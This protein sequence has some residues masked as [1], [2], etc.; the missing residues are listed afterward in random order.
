MVECI[1][2]RRLSTAALLILLS[3]ASF[4]AVPVRIVKT[5]LRPLIRAGAQSQVQFAVLVPQSVSTVDDGKWSMAGGRTTWS[6]AV[7]VPTAVSL[8]FHAAL[9]SLP[10][11]AVLVVRGAKTTTSYRA[12][13]LHRGELWSRI[14]PGDAL[15]FTLTVAAA[16]RDKVLLNIVS[17]QAGYRGL[18][19]GV[20]DNPYYR[21]LKAQAEASDNTACVTNY[22]CQVT[23]SNTPLGSATVALVVG[24][25]FECTGVLINDVPGDNTPYLLTA[26]HC[27]TGK[28]GGGNP[29]AASTLTVYW[30]AVTP[31][32][33]ALGSI[34]D[35]AAATQTGAQT[36]VEQ[37]DAWLIQLDVN[38]LV[39]DAQFAGF[40][41]SGGP[42]QGGYTVHHADGNDKQF[43]GWF[44]QAA[45]VQESDALGSSYLSNF[46]ETINQIGNIGPGASGSGLFDQNNHLV[47][48]LTLGRQTTDPTAYESC[49]AASPQA[50]TGSNGVA[51]F[52]SLAAVWNSKADTSSTTGNATIKSVLDPGSTGTLVVGTLPVANISLGVPFETPSLRYP[53]MFTWSAPGAGQC[54]AGGGVSGDGW[55]GVLASSGTQ[56]VTES[57]AGTVIYTLSCGYPSGRIAKTSVTVTWEPPTAVV[58]LTAPYSLWTTR[59]AILSW[60]SNVTPCAIR[61]G[62]LSLS[63]LSASGS[64]TTTQAVAAEVAYTLTCGPTNNQGSSTQQVLYVT[65][66]LVL[67]PTGT[68][69]ILG[70]TFDLQW[71]TAADSCI[72]SGGAPNDGWQGSAFTQS[73]YT[74]PN[75]LNAPTGALSPTVTTLGTYTYTLTCSSG[76]ISVQQSVSVTFENNTPY[77]TASLA[78]TSVIYSNSP[79]DFATV[80]WNSNV[81]TCRINTNPQLDYEASDPLGIPYQSQGS[82][83]LIPDAPGTY[84]ISVT[85]AIPGNNPTLVVSAPLTL[86]VLPPPPPTETI[87]IAPATVAVGGSY[88][89]S[90]S[91]TNANSC[92]GTGGIPYDDW[93]TNGGYSLPPS[94]TETFANAQAGQQYTFGISCE[95]ISPSIVQP[96]SAQAQLN[97]EAVAP[98]ESLQSSVTSIVAGGT[99]TL[100]WSS[101]NATACT[102]SGGGANG[103]PWTGSL[104]TSGSVAQ[105]ATVE[106]SF[107]YTLSCTE[108][109]ISSPAQHVTIVVSASTSS[110]GSGSSSKSGGGS[111]CISDL[112]LLAILLSI[113]RRFTLAR[114]TMGR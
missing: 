112:V 110:S 23:P 22:E 61:G 89:V 86:T 46:W 56:T 49:P 114:S 52:T 74:V 59:P 79:A 26:R 27:E 11:S 66:S 96:T 51:D 62:G 14:H 63:N 104:G 34:Y 80:T 32:G 85:C 20:Q 69:R 35:T 6:Y 17:L 77:T 15:Q 36:I 24:N 73:P 38:P 70:Q 2:R 107:T 97:V 58:A 30:D 57:S 90:W 28:L 94:G 16:E 41:A 93:D 47:G 48:S 65:P 42:V 50:P 44:G 18:G 13:D 92:E 54:T 91:S 105:T 1:L 108:G 72:A 83:A 9:S 21:Q 84:T 98:T 25:L 68:D 12:R 81:S 100:T 7:Q 109:G 78:Q 55:S 76:S 113:R 75:L 45:A 43:T 60:T 10:E 82:A 5:D 106:G 101:T 71:R 3:A 33:S 19:R 99:F 53:L 102:A 111:F 87:A 88:T 37:Q 4:A 103:S 39:S 67:E 95:S 31:C 40:D 8:S 64:T 29:G